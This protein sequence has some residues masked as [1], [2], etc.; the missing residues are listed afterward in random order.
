MLQPF[1]VAGNSATSPLANKK[2]AEIEVKIPKKIVAFF[3]GG[4]GD[5]ESFYGTGPYRNIVDVFEAFN[6]KIEDLSRSKIYIYKYLGYNEVCGE[7]DIAKFVIASLPNKMTK[8]YIIG[9]S[10]GGWNGAHLSGILTARGYNVIMLITL[11]P[12]GM[13]AIIKT[14]AD[15]FP[16]VPAPAAKFWINIRS[17]PKKKDD[18]D[19]IANLG[20]RWIIGNGPSVNYTADINHYNAKKLFFVPLKDK[21]SAADYMHESIRKEIMQ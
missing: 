20:E 10:L 18:S 5:K 8:I 3:I 14:S 17:A 21:K 19:T 11:D 16:K 4:A 9:H 12:V 2:R 1:R 6:P 15:I 13:S 7:Q